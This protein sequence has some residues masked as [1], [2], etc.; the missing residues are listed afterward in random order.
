MV[1]IGAAA[2]TWGWLGRADDA[3]RASSPDGA[4]TGVTRV[5]T[6][7]E[8]LR[9]IAM[10]AGHPVYWA[11]QVPGRAFEVTQNLNG[12]LIRYVPTSATAR[13]HNRQVLTVGTRLVPD[14]LKLV[15]GVARNP[16][17]SWRQLRGGGLAVAAR[18]APTNVGFAYPGAHVVVEVFDPVGAAMQLVISGR[19][20]KIE[21]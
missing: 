7:V 2:A 11:G 8:D 16:R 14:A 17:A 1:L 13:A 9:T 15:T 3:P 18:N 19:I 5:V 20:R 10:A 21:F 12:I 6:S 4:S